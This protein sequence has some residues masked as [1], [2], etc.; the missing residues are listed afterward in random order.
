MFDSTPVSLYPVPAGDQRSIRHLTLSGVPVDVMANVIILF[1]TVKEL[2]C[3]GIHPLQE[4][5]VC[6]CTVWLGMH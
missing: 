3:Y 6:T 4:V 2:E 1:S 5:S